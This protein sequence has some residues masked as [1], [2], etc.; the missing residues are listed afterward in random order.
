MFVGGKFAH[1]EG[2]GVLRF[3]AI[4]A[5]VKKPVDGLSSKFEFD[6]L[7]LFCKSVVYQLITHTFEQRNKGTIK[8]ID[9]K[10]DL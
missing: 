2:G 5:G 7:T 6:I 8:I 3:F 10:Q 9:L 1:P 4:P